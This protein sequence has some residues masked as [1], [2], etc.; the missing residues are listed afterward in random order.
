MIVVKPN[1]EAWYVNVHAGPGGSR[2]WDSSY[3]Y[4]SNGQHQQLTKAE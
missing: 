4:G 1:A 2:A 3:G